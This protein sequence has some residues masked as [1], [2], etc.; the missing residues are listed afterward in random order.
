MLFVVVSP[1]FLSPMRRNRRWAWFFIPAML[2]VSFLFPKLATSMAKFHF[3]GFACFLLG[4]QMAFSERWRNFILEARNGRWWLWTL[5]WALAAGLVAFLVDPPH[6]G[7]EISRWAATLKFSYVVLAVVCL[8]R[9]VAC[10]RWRAPESWVKIT[11]VI[12]G[13]HWI[14]IE[15][16]TK[17]GLDII[18]KYPT[19]MFFVVFALTS[20]ICLSAGLALRRFVPRIA[21]CLTGGRS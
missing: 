15:L 9:L 17:I 14:V 19:L 11:F 7:V 10:S 13:L 3:L 16:L 20:A 6:E 4:A 5:I 18:K 12:Y 21:S 1:L 2:A 8:Q